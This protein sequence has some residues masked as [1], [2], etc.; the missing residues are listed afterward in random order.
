MFPDMNPE[1]RNLNAATEMSCNVI[2]LAISITLLSLIKN[3]NVVT[4]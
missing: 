4:E 3:V 2:L 1:D